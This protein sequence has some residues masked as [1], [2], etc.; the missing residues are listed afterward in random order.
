MADAQ[1]RLTDAATTAFGR[2]L[3]N[4][5][6]EALLYGRTAAEPL[7]GGADE[8][9]RQARNHKPRWQPAW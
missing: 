5:H 8:W 3:V 6:A 1:G 7:P 9:R 4:K 2:A